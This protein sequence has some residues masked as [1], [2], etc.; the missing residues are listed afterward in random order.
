[1]DI[2]NQYLLFMILSELRPEAPI[3][4]DPPFMN[5][6]KQYILLVTA[7]LWV[8]INIVYLWKG[9]DKQTNKQTNKQNSIVENGKTI[10]TGLQQLLQ[11]LPRLF[12]FGR[13]IISVKSGQPFT[14]A[15]SK[16]TTVYHCIAAKRPVL[17]NCIL[18]FLKHGNTQT[19]IQ[20]HEYQ[21]KSFSSLMKLWNT[22]RQKT[23]K[24]FFFIFAET[25]PEKSWPLH[26][27]LVLAWP[28]LQNCILKFSESTRIQIH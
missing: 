11:S 6:S 16:P 13:S 18:K 4:H 25:S 1:M 19:Q 15:K 24:L 3:Y 14:I 8:E 5:I 12:L 21:K 20:I 23:G 9:Y 27:F 28:D 10:R 17:Q 2:F 7:S 22:T 26:G